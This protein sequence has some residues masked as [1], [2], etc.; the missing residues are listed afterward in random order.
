MALRGE[1]VDLVRLH[2]LDD[3][4]EAHRVGHVAV[5]QKE[6]CVFLVA[7][8]V[9][10]VDAVGVEVRCAAFDVVDDVAFVE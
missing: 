6:L 7:V 3:E 4:C 5:M 8:F 9:Q 10:M 2:L 1:V